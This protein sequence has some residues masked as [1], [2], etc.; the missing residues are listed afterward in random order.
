MI[1]QQVSVFL[2]N[3]SGSLLPL[4]ETLGTAGINI[5]ALSIAETAD[6][7]IIRMIV[8]DTEKCEK[9]LKEHEFT[10]KVRDVIEV[11][12]AD[13]P[14]ALAA[15]LKHFAD[16]DVNVKYMYGYSNGGTAYLIMKVDDPEKAIQYLK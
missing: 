14:G 11:Q 4:V 15:Q 9:V 16:N 1:V 10:V 6:Y 13:Q 7:G 2:E 12:T 5:R 3:K 8:S